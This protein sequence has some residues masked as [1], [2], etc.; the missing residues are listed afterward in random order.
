LLD[1]NRDYSRDEILKKLET[2][3]IFKGSWI[4]E[5]MSSCLNEKYQALF[6][7]AVSETNRDIRSD[8]LEQMKGVAFATGVFNM[9][10]DELKQQLGE[11]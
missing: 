1:D 4:Y 11:I 5:E 10:E 2:L 6:S 7:E 3:K 8:K 9:I